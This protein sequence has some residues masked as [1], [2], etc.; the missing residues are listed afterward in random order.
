MFPQP[1]S[2]GLV[3]TSVGYLPRLRQMSTEPSQVW[4]IFDKTN[5]V[6]ECLL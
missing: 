2:M 1:S 3:L 5:D 4:D 6:N